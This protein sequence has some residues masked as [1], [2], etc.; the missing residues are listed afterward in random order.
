M[1][2]TFI[3]MPGSGKSCMGRIVSRKF[4]MRIID[5]D[6]LI[7]KNEG[8]PLHRIIEEDGMDR[9]KELEE[10]TL[11]S[12]E[13]DNVIISPGGSA[14]YYENV[15]KRF[16]EKGIVVYLYI[17]LDTMKERLGDYSKRGIVL[18]E[19]Q[20]LDDLYAE[21]APLFKKYADITVSCDGRAYSKYQAELLSKIEKY[22]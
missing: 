13:E 9:F 7:E 11:L 6:K 17:S 15:M 10:R 5:G 21:R 8:R 16:K 19:G 3:G 12:I 2:V 4:K 20:T 14:I 18:K 22:L 1:T